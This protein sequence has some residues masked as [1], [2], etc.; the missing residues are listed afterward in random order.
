MLSKNK[1]LKK[2]NGDVDESEDDDDEEESESE[3]E[4]EVEEKPK[5][6]VK[7]A[8]NEQTVLFVISHMILLQKL[9]KSILRTF[10]TNSLRIT[11]FRQKLNQPKGTAFVAFE[12]AEDCDTCVKEGPKISSTSLLLPDD[13][14]SRYVLRAEFCQSQKLFNARMLKSL[15][16]HLPTND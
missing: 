16:L 14:D 1:W 10:R 15:Q 9:C 6:A 2:Q 8:S 7:A 13:V 3:E 11:R 5:R 12:N 4:E